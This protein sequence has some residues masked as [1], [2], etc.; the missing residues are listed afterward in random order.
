M[1]NLIRN[2][3]SNKW[4][5]TLGMASRW[6]KGKKI[7]F[8][9]RCVQSSLLD[10]NSNYIRKKTF[11]FHKAVEK[12]SLMSG[13]SLRISLC[14]SGQVYQQYTVRKWKTNRTTW[15]PPT[16]NSCRVSPATL[17]NSSYPL[18]LLWTFRIWSFILALML[19]K[20]ETFKVFIKL[21]EA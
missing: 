12:I 2:L 14:E 21:K 1:I 5:T 20:K 19:M 11:V 7:C 16:T 9:H 10:V 15:Q 18:L 3:P 17:T 6:L 8:C 4:K 13:N